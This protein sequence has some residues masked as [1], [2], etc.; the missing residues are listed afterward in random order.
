MSRNIGSAKRELGTSWVLITDLDGTLLDYETY[1]FEPAL[2]SL[3]RLRA[4]EIPVVLCSSKTDAEIRFIQHEM[5]DRGPII[6]ENGG[7]V[8]IPRAMLTTPPPG[9][10]ISGDDYLLELG[11]PYPEIVKKLHR[12]RER[13]RL[14]GFSDLEDREVARLCNLTTDEA[15]RARNREYDEP[16]LIEEEDPRRVEELL[17]E[18]EAMSLQCVRGGR[19]HHLMGSNDKGK[20]VTLLLATLRHRW[21]A[22]SSIGLGDSRNDLTM[23]Q[24]VDLPVILPGPGRDPDKALVLALPDAKIA[25]HPG[26]RGWNAAV[27]EWLNSLPEA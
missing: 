3:G 18:A 16:V 23:L 21:E 9:S 26:P 4:L 24:A 2:P 13:F 7:A 5:N 17:R 10:R 20:A 12:L 14:R 19:F 15:R 25:P 27:D 1:S 6:V 11:V 22:V 8:R